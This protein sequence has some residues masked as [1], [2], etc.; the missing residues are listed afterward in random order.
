MI[1]IQV[2]VQVNHYTQFTDRLKMAE[3]G[4]R[5][6]YGVKA[7][8]HVISVSILEGVLLNLLNLFWIFFF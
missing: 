1:Y 2:N 6:C 8:I 7:A 3:K 5:L 4:Q